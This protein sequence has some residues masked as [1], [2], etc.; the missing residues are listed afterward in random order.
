MAENF[1]AKTLRELTRILFV[2]FWMMLF[3]VAGCAV[4]TYILCV[5]ATP[6]YRSTVT[7]IF[8]QP[9]G[10]SPVFQESPERPLEV[11]VKAQQQ[12][13]MSDLVL[14]RT[15]VLAEDAALRGKWYALR[16]RMEEA[17]SRT[18]RPP[19][20]PP[21]D[22]LV[23]INGE[24][25][26]FL[27]AP[28][29]APRVAEVMARRQK[30]LLDLRD[31]VR[32]RTPGGEQ[33]AMT[34]SFQLSVDRPAPRDRADSHLNAMYAADILADMYMV[35]FRQFQEELSGAAGNFMDRV[36]REHEKVVQRAQQRLDA[37][38]AA[39]LDA[40]GDI[41]IL[42]QL[43][44]SGTEHGFQIIATR[45]R[46]AT[47][48]LTDELARARSIHDLLRK[49]IPAPAFQPDGVGKL[50][51][52]DV[53][54]AIAVIPPEVL[55]TNA[56]VLRLSEHLIRLRSREANLLAQYTEANRAVLDIR[57]ELD[58]GQR[59]MLAELVAHARSLE[60]T[61]ASLQKRLEENE[62][63]LKTVE[64]RLDRINRKLTEYQ[65]LKND[66]TVALK[67]HQDLQEEQV[68]AFAGDE[69]ARA[70]ITISKL[71]SASRPD[72]EKPTQPLLWIYTL[73]A[74]GVGVLLATAYAFLADHFDHTLRTTEEA[75]RYLGVPVVGSVARRGRTLLTAV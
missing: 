54:R 70:A 6:I 9:V 40:P 50:P 55:E 12:I 30:D 43:L 64:A 24:I 36:V 46:E 31:D 37:F 49:Q 73:I 23:M 42:E 68:A 29:I 8:K 22:D 67:Q 20:E 27:D 25:D 41:A 51:E 18:A 57:D 1:A 13:V 7:L 56:I 52:A 66:V 11:F 72:P 39:E 63:N 4:P 5:R 33:V 35:R 69:R 71:D 26:A 17:R 2:R 65:R 58:R 62:Q 10:K 32:F 3:V 74:A 28:E 53:R 75:E 21:P 61:A 19:A 45:A 14:A 44:K 59:Q 34:E 16:Q 48:R 47:L 38:I 60:I 15:A